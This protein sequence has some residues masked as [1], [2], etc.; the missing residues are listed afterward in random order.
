MSVQIPR[1]PL[2]KPDYFSPKITIENGLS[3][4][5]NKKVPVYEVRKNLHDKVIFILCKININEAS[6]PQEL[7]RWLVKVKPIKKTTDTE[8][9]NKLDVAGGD[10][11]RPRT[12]ESLHK[13]RSEHK[14]KSKSKESESRQLKTKKKSDEA[15]TKEVE[16]QAAVILNSVI[17]EA[18]RKVNGTPDPKVEVQKPRKA[19]RKLSR[20]ASSVPTK[21][22]KN[23]NRNV[24][25][26]VVLVY[27]DSAIAKESVKQV[28]HDILNRERWVYMLKF[29]LFGKW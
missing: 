3:A 28:L 20:S 23:L 5:E 29:V 24:K 19:P 4:E 1:I 8:S 27:A 21:Y 14:S 7:F 12:K 2:D 10:C 17:D 15:R 18:D 6:L 26:P 22:S 25:P 13:P 11:R 16:V 9:K